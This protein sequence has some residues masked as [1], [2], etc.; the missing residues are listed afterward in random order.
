MSIHLHTETSLGKNSMILRMTSTVCPPSMTQTWPSSALDRAILIQTDNSTWG[1]TYMGRNFIQSTQRLMEMIKIGTIKPTQGADNS[2]AYQPVNSMIS[3]Y[4]NYTYQMVGYIALT[5]HFTRILVNFLA[6][7]NSEILFSLSFYAH[8]IFL[9]ET[10]PWVPYK[11]LAY[12][13]TYMPLCRGF[14]IS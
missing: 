12:G 2:E 10:H 3:S 14:R 1:G 11:Q 9:C 6:R 8:I 7:D 13:E 4:M 5:P